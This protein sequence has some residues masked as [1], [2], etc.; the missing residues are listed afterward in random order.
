MQNLIR[1][2]EMTQQ[3]SSPDDE[4]EAEALLDEC[5]VCSDQKREMLFLPCGHIVVCRACAARVKKCLLCKEYVDHRVK[6]EDCLVCSENPASVLFRPCNH[7]VACDT[8]AGIMK[9]CVE[10]RT[11]IDEVVPYRVCCG[12]KIGNRDVGIKPTNTGGDATASAAA[13]SDVGGGLSA[14]MASVDLSS[15]AG[16]VSG[17]TSGGTASGHDNVATM[18]NGGKDTSKADVQKLQEQLND[19]KEQ[20]NSHADFL[21]FLTI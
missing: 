6:V 20:V 19:I 18:N 4:E 15:V 5:M 8:C 9:K 21:S 11:T 2:D 17:A 16:G 14:A 1:G 3:V 12:G 10:C 7:M 13:G